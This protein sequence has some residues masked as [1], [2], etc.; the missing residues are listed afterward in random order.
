MTVPGELRT[1]VGRADELATLSGLVGAAVRGMGSCAVIEGEAGSGKTRL[2]TEALAGASEAGLFVVSGGADELDDRPLGALA[3][4]LGPL[5]VMAPD[6][7]WAELSALLIAPAASEPA[8]GVGGAADVG[9]RLVDLVLAYMERVA[10]SRPVVLAIEDLHWADPVTLRVVRALGQWPAELPLLLFLTMRPWPRSAALERVVSDL[11]SKGARHLPLGPLDSGDS[12]TL[13]ATIT[14]ARAG[15]RLAAQVARAAGNPLYIIELTRALRDEEALSFEGGWVDVVDDRVSPTLELGVQ[16]RLA[17]LPASTVEAIKVAAVLG[18]RVPTATL[19]AVMAVH[20]V[21]L[22]S[23]LEPAVQAGLLD[24]L[25][26]GLSFRHDLIRD[27]VYD[28]MPAAIRQGLHREAARVLVA[29]GAPL[30]EAAD[31]LALGAAPGDGVAVGWLVAA[32]QQ[33]ATRAPATAVRFLERALELADPDDPATDDLVC[34]LAPLL[35]QTGRAPDAERLSRQILDRGPVP[36]TEVALR[37]ALG[38]VLWTKGWLEPAAV[39]LDAAASVRGVPAADLVGP[40]A[41]AGHVRLFLGEP[42][43]AARRAAL[44]L[45]GGHDAGDDFAVCLAQQTMAVAADARG[46]SAEAVAM[47]EAAVATAEHSHQSRVGHLHPHLYLGLIL[48]DAD[49]VDDAEAAL[50]KGRRRA[51]ARGTVV[52]LPLYH[53]FLATRRIVTG[54]WDDALA[55]VAAGLAAADEV[56]TRLY[57]PFLYGV[58]SWVAVQRGE[59]ARAQ[60]GLDDALREFLAATT[61][62]WQVR[63]TE[64]LRSAGARWPMEWGLWIGALLQEAHGDGAQALA[65]LEDAWAIGEPLRYF[66]A[67]R[68][69]APDLVRLAVAAD[70]RALA[71]AVVAEAEQGARR[72]GMAGTEGTALRCRGLFD[73][74]GAALLDAAARLRQAGATTELAFTL[75]DAGHSLARAGRTADAVDA[76]QEALAL[77]DGIGATRAGAR[78]EAALRALGVRRRRAGAGDRPA[79]GWEALTASELAVARLAADG[80]TNRQIGERLFISHRTVETHLAHVFAKLALTSRSQLAAEVA[81]RA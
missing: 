4:A 44:A 54:E 57:V 33:V 65:Q 67:H 77:F 11:K 45:A 55:E 59:L 76:L 19:A 58:A 75:E 30:V 78:T 21:R 7:V 3:S 39:E 31:H 51:E 43:D 61:P 53:C 48:L 22:A 5:P 25:P 37:R 47:A 73:D 41:L 8:T 74:D 9:Y 29:A 38:E 15:P 50:Q 10:S 66:L 81:R 2:L 32:G 72:S 16:R 80:L 52:W 63:A 70:S 26:D 42:E 27:A 23:T 49:R 34:D 68:F 36:S 71:A 79:S 20:P 64:E 28:A 56:G 13:V 35:I 24:A 18:E 12:A 62:A 69:F 40:A 46:R 14:G 1:L 17:A 60:A 6:P